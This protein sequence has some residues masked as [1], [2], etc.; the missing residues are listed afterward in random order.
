MVI[1]NSCYNV[2]FYAKVAHN[3]DVVLYFDTGKNFTYINE[4]FINEYKNNIKRNTKIHI[5]MNTHYFKNLSNP[6]YFPDGYVKFIEAN[7]ADDII[8]NLENS[9]YL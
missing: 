9:N 7:G 2:Y 3:C 8:K 6:V 4:E 1:N 5:G